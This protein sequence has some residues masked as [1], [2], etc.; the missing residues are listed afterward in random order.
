MIEGYK[1]SNYDFFYHNMTEKSF[2][3]FL[4]LWNDISMSIIITLVLYYTIKCKNMPKMIKSYHRCFLMFFFVDF[5]SFFSVPFFQLCK[6]IFF[7]FFSFF[8]KNPLDHLREVVNFFN[9]FNVF[10]C[11]FKYLSIFE[12]KKWK[13]PRKK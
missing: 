8:A 12:K 9:F 10:Y 2:L 11:W 5:S 4:T 1:M 7:H 3:K 13:N 6:G